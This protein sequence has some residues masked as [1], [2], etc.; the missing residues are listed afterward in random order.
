MVDVNDEEL[1]IVLDNNSS[2]L[3][4]MIYH[5]LLIATVKGGLLT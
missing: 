4:V 3:S 1:N 5:A 2:N